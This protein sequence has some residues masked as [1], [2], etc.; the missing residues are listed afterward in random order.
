MADA[1]KTP[2]TLAGV[3]AAEPA[4]AARTVWSIARRRLRRNPPALI[5]LSFLVVI[6]LIAILGPM[7]GSAFLSIDPFTADPIASLR[8]G[9][10]AH[11]LGTDEIGRDVLARL[12]LGSR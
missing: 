8:G 4:A 10:L 7:V 12:M 6:H 5:A 3:H 9:N 11:P 1:I 2:V